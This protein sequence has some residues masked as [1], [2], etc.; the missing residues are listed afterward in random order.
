MVPIEGGEIPPQAG[1]PAV[2]PVAG[3]EAAHQVA[4]V[5][6]QRLS[7]PIE[8]REAVATQKPPQFAGREIMEVRGTEV[9]TRRHGGRKDQV[10]DR[11]GPGVQ[12]VQEVVVAVDVGDGLQRDDH[13][14]G[15]SAGPLA[16]VLLVRGGEVFQIV[17]VVP[18]P[19]VFDGGR[20]GVDGG[21]P[22]RDAS[23]ACC[24]IACAACQVQH[25]PALAHLL[26]KAIALQMEG[27]H[28][29]LEAVVQIHGVGNQSGETG[30]GRMVRRLRPRV[31]HEGNR[32]RGT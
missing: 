5:E 31:P 6:R 32:G 4:D 18:G 23:Q 28:S 11:E 12:P 10:A 26:G 21:D 9:T 27:E 15:S 24:A 19:G 14:E 8:D 20:L 29:P 2:P 17:P 25:S 22:A 30:R 1:L 13:L 16:P 7:E 3:V